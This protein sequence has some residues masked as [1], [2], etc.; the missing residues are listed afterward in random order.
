MKWESAWKRILPLLKIK[1]NIKLPTFSRKIKSE[2]KVSGCDC[3][4]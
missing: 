1:F 2:K 4:R 3:C